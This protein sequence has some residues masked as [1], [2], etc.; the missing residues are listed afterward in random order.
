MKR[1]LYAF[2]CLLISFNTV[3]QDRKF[4]NSD[5]EMYFFLKENI[6]DLFGEIIYAPFEVRDNSGKCHLDYSKSKMIIIK[7]LC[8]YNKITKETSYITDFEKDDNM[9]DY[10]I[11]MDAFYIE[12]SMEYEFMS[13]SFDVESWDMTKPFANR[14]LIIYYSYEKYSNRYCLNFR[15]FVKTKEKIDTIGG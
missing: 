5:E 7:R 11:S 8:L 15:Y 14:K 10:I 4:K 6:S 12:N 3:S 1:I 13:Y 2:I 9:G